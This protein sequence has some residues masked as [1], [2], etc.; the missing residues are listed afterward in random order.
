MIAR[1]QTRASG[2]AR[3]RIGALAASIA[4][5]AGALAP[6]AQAQERM[7]LI[8]DTEI[9][10]ILYKDAAPLLEAAG[11]DPKNVDILLIG[12]KDLNAFAA[13]SQ[14]GVF[15]GLILESDN[16]NELKGVMA[17]EVGH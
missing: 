16:P 17:H 8:R 5:A 14:M 3:R 4:L 1:F 2:R 6:V 13:P 9:E 7:S 10:E 12:S 11:F 15:T